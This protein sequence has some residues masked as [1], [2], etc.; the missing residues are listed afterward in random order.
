[1][2]IKRGKIILENLQ[3]KSIDKA[4]ALAAALT[5]IENECGIHEVEITLKNPF[6]CPWIN[7]RDLNETEMEILLCGLLESLSK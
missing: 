5:V 4:K 3:I 2:K 1:M 6:I 7:K